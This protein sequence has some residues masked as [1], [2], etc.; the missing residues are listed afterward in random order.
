MSEDLSRRKQAADLVA[1]MRSIGVRMEEVAG[2]FRSPRLAR[3]SDIAWLDQEAVLV[4]AIAMRPP[5]CHVRSGVI[6]GR[7][8]CLSRSPADRGPA[9]Q[10]RQG[11]TS[12]RARSAFCIVWVGV[13]AVAVF[14]VACLAA[15]Q[16]NEAAGTNLSGPAIRSVRRNP[17]TKEMSGAPG[18][19]HRSFKAGEEGRVSG[20]GEPGEV[21]LL[22]SVR[23]I[24]LRAGSRKARSS[25]PKK[26]RASL[27][28][29]QP[30]LRQRVVRHPI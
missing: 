9:S 27:G 29:R 21:R 28:A 8:R 30:R 19:A 17:P 1:H 25:A 10:P 11:R 13:W 20:E 23:T 12:G 24:S 5:I 22:G 6:A 14:C 4:T 16:L 18:R 15:A 2:A 26:Q 3:R 7:R